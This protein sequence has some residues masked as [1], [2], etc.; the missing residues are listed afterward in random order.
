MAYMYDKHA[1]G[2]PLAVTDSC[3]G[4]VYIKQLVMKIKISNNCVSHQQLA[5]CCSSSLY[6]D[7][8]TIV[9]VAEEIENLRDI[10][11]LLA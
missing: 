5:T 8:A 11:Y 1:V 2:V 6:C 4:H 9:W 10:I 7:K 3:K